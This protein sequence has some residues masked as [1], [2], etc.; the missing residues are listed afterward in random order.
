[1]HSIST[2][3]AAAVPSA[4]T[5]R[6]SLAASQ[7]GSPLSVPSFLPASV[8]HQLLEEQVVELKAKGGKVR[9][10]NAGD[11]RSTVALRPV[12]AQASATEAA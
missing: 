11:G 3:V 12:G 9:K 5:A 6:V 7:L 4:S 1:M 8:V 10:G 2:V